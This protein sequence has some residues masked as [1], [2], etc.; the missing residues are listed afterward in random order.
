MTVLVEDG[1]ARDAIKDE[2]LHAFVG[3]DLTK[4]ALQLG[5][6]SISAGGTEDDDDDSMN[7]GGNGST[8]GMSTRKKLQALYNL[9]VIASQKLPQLTELLQGIVPP[10]QRPQQEDTAAAASNEDAPLL[11]QI[12]KELLKAQAELQRSVEL[13]EAVLDMEAA[14]REFKIKPD[15]KEEL[16]DIYQEL[17]G[18][19]EEMDICLADT[20]DMW[21][22]AC[23]KGNPPKVRL[24]SS[25]EDGNVGWQFRLPST[26]DA[27]IL[28]NELGGTV[29]VHRIL[30]N[31]VYFTTKELRELAGKKNDLAAE[32]D[33]HQRQ[34]VTQAMKVAGTYQ[35]VLERTSE[36][37]ATLDVLVALAHLAAYSPHGY[38]RPTLTD[39]DD[40]GLGI[41]LTDAR[42][43]CVE[44]QDNVEYIANDVKLVFGQSNFCLVTGPNMGG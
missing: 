32:Y 24:E 35:P 29:K 21:A 44:L 8:A 27:K 9:Y 41:T 19:E 2:G 20:N 36:W 16:Q 4:L 42:H 13:A 11:P 1:V 25:G 22:Q 37:V 12:Y 33:L 15:Y 5:Q 23:G 26:N 34:I 38:C 7:A 18:V 14:P 40:D 3:T 39:G 17:Q 30:K 28:Q 10:D 6:C 43:P 31:G